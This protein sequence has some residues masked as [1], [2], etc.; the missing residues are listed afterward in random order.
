MQM[1]L[2]KKIALAAMAIAALM[3]VGASFSGAVNLLAPMATIMAGAL[4]ALAIAENNP[5]EQ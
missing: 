5:R 2:A 3:F 4:I 1:M